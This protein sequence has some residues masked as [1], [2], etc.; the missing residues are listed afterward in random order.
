MK[1][2]CDLYIFIIRALAIDGA[3][4]DDDGSVSWASL[5]TVEPMDLA[6]SMTDV[7]TKS[8]T[9]VSRQDAAVVV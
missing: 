9:S 7:R 6:E 1:H 5:I 3:R 8:V 2:V 4:F